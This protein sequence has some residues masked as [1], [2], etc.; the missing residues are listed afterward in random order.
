LEDE[1]DRLTNPV[2]ADQSSGFSEKIGSRRVFLKKLLAG[3]YLNWA[4]SISS[5]ENVTTA[6]KLECLR[7]ATAAYRLNQNDPNVLTLI[8]RLATDEDPEVSGPAKEVYNPYKHFAAPSLVLN[9]LGS[10]AMQQGDFDGAVKFFELARKKDPN[11][12]MILNNLSYS[13]LRN[14]DQ[15]ANRALQLVDQ[16]LRLISGNAQWAQFRPNFLDTRGTALVKL[17]RYEEAIAAFEKALASQPE[18]IELLKQLIE[19]YENT[20]LD[21]SVLI[22]RIDRL[23]ALNAEKN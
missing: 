6:D 7:L 1:I 8:A 14:N 3:V 21:T 20:G 12:P 9:Q 13:W 11:N 2:N 5:G 15:D 4:G 10:A 17:G 22:G 23:E 18:D 16:G 19:C